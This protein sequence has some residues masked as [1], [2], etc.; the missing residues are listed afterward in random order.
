MKKLI[1]GMAVLAASTVCAQENEVQTVSIPAYCVQLQTLEQVLDKYSELP[2]VRGIS[3]REVG[4]EK[5]DSPMVIFINQ[6][7]MTFTIAEQVSSSHFCIIAMGADFQ[8]V[9]DQIREDVLKR[10]QNSKS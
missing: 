5:L 3:S 2:Y 1:V 7:E 4:G 8:P 6:Q 9:P 10:R